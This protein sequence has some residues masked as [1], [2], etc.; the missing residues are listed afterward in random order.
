MS[1]S[2]RRSAYVFEVVLGF[3]AVLMTGTVISAVV[4]SVIVQRRA[5]VQ[6]T[7]PNVP[8]VTEQIPVAANGLAIV[9]AR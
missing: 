7:P 2:S 8:A 3:A 1:L 6:P 4:A 5:P 9:P